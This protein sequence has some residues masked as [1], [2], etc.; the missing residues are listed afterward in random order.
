MMRCPCPNIGWHTLPS[1][2][3]R[4]ILTQQV[5]LGSHGSGDGLQ[6]SRPRVDEGS[7]KALGGHPPARSR[8]LLVVNRLGRG[9][10]LSGEKENACV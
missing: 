1:T 10:I 4:L 7:M 8:L 9:Y 6:T 3:I 2:I 5:I